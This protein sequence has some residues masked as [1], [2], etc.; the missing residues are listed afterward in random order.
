MEG[1]WQRQAHMEK[2]VYLCFYPVRHVQRLEYE[3]P[4]GENKMEMWSVAK[5]EDHAE[6]RLN[7]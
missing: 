1:R 5:L 6:P 4:P 3:G 2:C 7:P